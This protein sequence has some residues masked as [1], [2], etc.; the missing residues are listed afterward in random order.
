MIKKYIPD[1]LF[2]IFFL[3]IAVLVAGKPDINLNLRPAQVNPPKT[4]KKEQI[5]KIIRSISVPHKM[6]EER[7]I[8]AIDGSYTTSGAGTAV[9][10][11]EGSCTLIGILHGEEKKAVFREH[12]GSVVTLTVGG[13]LSDG[14]IITEISSVSVKVEKGQER[15]ELKIFDVNNYE[16]AKKRKI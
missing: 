5:T 4:D 12:T 2:I 7:N 9:S 8:F 10:L 13:K 11:P 6:L 1:I 14:Y 3:S 15:R 16:P